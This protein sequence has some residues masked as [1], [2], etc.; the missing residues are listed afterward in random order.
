MASQRLLI[1]IDLGTSSVKVS[2]TDTE[3][4]VLTT[5][6]VG[7]E[8]HAP[9]SGWAETDPEDWWQATVAAARVVLAEAQSRP[10][11][12]PSDSTEI[13]GIGLSGQMH[14]LVLADATGLPTRSAML[15]PD[16]RATELL[17]YFRGLDPD[18]LERLGNPLSPNM[19][20]P[21][22]L[23][24]A[25][26]DRDAYAAATWALQPKDWIRL[27][28]TGLAAAEPSDASAT[29]LYDLYRDGWA[30]DLVEDLG[31]RSELLPDLL[32]WAGVAS[33]GLSRAAAAELGFAP[34][35]PVAAGGGDTAVAAIGS[36]LTR[37]GDVQL[38]V[39]TGGQ[40]VTP[41]ADLPPLGA[42]N[43][44]HLYRGAA[45]HGWYAM[46]AVLNAGLALDWARRTLGAEWDELYAAGERSVTW[47]DPIFLP[48]LT[49]ERTPYLDPALRGAWVGLGLGTTREALLRSTLE[50]VAHALRDAFDAVRAAEAAEVVRLAGGG[51]VSPGWR[52]LLASVL[53]RPL[54]SM[55]VHNVSARGA[56]LLGGVAAGIVDEADLAGRLAPAPGD[57][58]EPDASSDLVD[59]RRAAFHDALKRLR[60]DLPPS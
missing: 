15:H 10:G 27:R 30:L 31:L 39:G 19:A 18:L 13:A 54:Q 25:T 12:E 37:P 53:Q 50:G 1:G 42:E 33:G 58:T 60:P 32:P 52:R 36:G 45:S 41:V 5:A 17:E 24:A 55:D 16:T 8:V 46:G 7:Y 34:G 26:H 51:S 23:W 28:L 29:L 11:A 43:G 21:M 14:G 49:G 57:L 38:T 4:T 20:G 3:G 48:H 6:T 40:V 9:H 22:L 2:A 59:Q 47:D 56:A 35:V 44:T